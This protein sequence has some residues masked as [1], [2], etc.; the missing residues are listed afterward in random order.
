MTGWIFI[1]GV[2]LVG[3]VAGWGMALLYVTALHPRDGEP[4][5]HVD[6]D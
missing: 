5:G 1:G 6:R 3:L 2:L 4:D